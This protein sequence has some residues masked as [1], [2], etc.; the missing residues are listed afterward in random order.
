MRNKY[1]AWEG[2][3]PEF[4][5]NQLVARA[6]LYLK[7]SLQCSV[8]FKERSAAPSEQPDCLGFKYGSKSFLIE[9]KASRADFLADKKKGFRRNPDDGMGDE[10][11][12][13]APVGM[14]KLNEMP[15]GWGLIE[16]M[17]KETKLQQNYPLRMA[18][19]SKSFTKNKSNEIKFL[20]SAIRRIEISMAV[21]IEPI[22]EEK[23]N[24]K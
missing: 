3:V 23:E 6:F 5:H 7:Y 9:C 20:T 24:D 15:D 19:D 8:V 11:Y 14:L 18:R 21:F 10:R 22:T 2:E 13:I 12:F 17:P 1:K 4:T 16:M